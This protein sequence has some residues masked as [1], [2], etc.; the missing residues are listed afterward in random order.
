MY[1]FFYNNGCLSKHW[2]NNAK[3]FTCCKVLHMS[4]NSIAIHVQMFQCFPFQF[5]C[6][7]QWQ[8]LFSMPKFSPHTQVEWRWEICK[9]L[10]SK[11]TRWRYTHLWSWQ[12]RWT[13][14]KRQKEKK[15]RM[16]KENINYC[17]EQSDDNFLFFLW[18]NSPAVLAVQG[19]LNFLGNPCLPG[20]K[21][22]KHIYVWKDI[23][24]MV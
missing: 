4:K 2:Q 23:H 3:I 21:K 24:R 8:T 17:V 9:T 16:L 20:E 5:M 15:K 6:C 7:F 11:D 18:L 22:R 1:F 14:E 10:C 13:L 12:T 19:F